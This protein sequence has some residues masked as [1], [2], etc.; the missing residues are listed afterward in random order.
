MNRVYF[1][2]NY[3]YNPAGPDFAP[4]CFV[5]IGFDQDHTIIVSRVYKSYNLPKM[6]SLARKMALERNLPLTVLAVDPMIEEIYT[7]ERGPP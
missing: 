3:H 1:L 5:W 7:R 6:L 4:L 2:T